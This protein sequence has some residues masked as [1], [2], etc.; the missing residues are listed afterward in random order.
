MGWKPSLKKEKKNNNKKKQFTYLPIRI[1]TPKNIYMYTSNAI[2]TD[3]FAGY[4]R[5]RL[6]NLTE[7]F[8]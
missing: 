3:L 6:S 4:T 8:K 5:I 7:S 1:I 2:P